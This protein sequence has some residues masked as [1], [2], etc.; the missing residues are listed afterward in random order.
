VILKGKNNAPFADGAGNSDDPMPGG[1]RQNSAGTSSTGPSGQWQRLPSSS[2]SEHGR[3]A[4]LSLI[5]GGGGMI[6]ICGGRARVRRLCGLGCLAFLPFNKPSLSNRRL[7]VYG[8]ARAAQTICDLC[9]RARRPEGDKFAGFFVGPAGHGRRSWRPQR[10]V[11]CLPI[12][13]APFW[14]L[15]LL[16]ASARLKRSIEPSHFAGFRLPPASMPIHPIPEMHCPRSTGQRRCG[17]GVFASKH[18]QADSRAGD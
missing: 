8:R 2:S 6:R 1:H 4:R 15:H 17:S 9:G 5:G 12:R 7:F 13:A 11:P 10:L 16:R 14:R 18:D 3:T